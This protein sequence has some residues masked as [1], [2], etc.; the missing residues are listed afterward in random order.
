MVNSD[1]NYMQ[2]NGLC[3]AKLLVSSYQSKQLFEFTFNHGVYVIQEKR[4]KRDP[5]LSKPGSPFCLSP[6][7][8]RLAKIAR[9]SMTTS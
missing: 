1:V 8:V 9:I 7:F 4:D 5:H 3:C 6:T 2:F